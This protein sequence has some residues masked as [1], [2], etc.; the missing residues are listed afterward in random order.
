MR[1]VVVAVV[2]WNALLAD[3]IPPFFIDTV[4]ALGRTEV[5]AAGQNPEWITE[6]SGFLYGYLIKDDPEPTKRSY[7]SAD[8][9]DKSC[10]PREFGPCGGSAYGFRERHDQGVAPGSRQSQFFRALKISATVIS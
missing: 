4:A 5:K 8:R 1:F 6:A 10:L 9:P 7:E 2:A 3:Q